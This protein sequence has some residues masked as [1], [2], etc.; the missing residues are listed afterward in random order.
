MKI[1]VLEAVI[2]SGF[3]FSIETIGVYSKRENAVKAMTDLPPENKNLVYNIE[4]FNLNDPPVNIFKDMSEDI[5]SLMDSGV[6]DQLVGEDGRFYY[7]L[8]DF[9]REVAKN[10]K[11]ERDNRENK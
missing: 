11:D 10:M 7:E 5:K 4:I 1:Y 3:S 9:G 2:G 8:T 6:I